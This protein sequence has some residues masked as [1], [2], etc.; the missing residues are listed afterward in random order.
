MATI[1]VDRNGGNDEN[2]GLTSE[3]A[4]QNPAEAVTIM[5]ETET[6]A[7]GDEERVLGPGP[8]NIEIN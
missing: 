5:N 4:V 2:D 6:N 7:D 8:H 3:T 1:Y